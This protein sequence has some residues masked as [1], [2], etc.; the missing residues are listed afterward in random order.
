MLIGLRP[1]VRSSGVVGE[2][3]LAAF[4]VSCGIPGRRTKLWV[5][6]FVVHNKRPALNVVYAKSC[7]FQ[8]RS[9]KMVIT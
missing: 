2:I 8:S 6:S 3:D 7:I 5:C 1:D 9:I 4:F